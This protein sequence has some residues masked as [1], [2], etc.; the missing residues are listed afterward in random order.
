MV[1]YRNW[2]GLMKGTLGVEVKKGNSSVTRTLNPDRVYTSP[3]GKGEVSLPP[4]LHP[5]PYTLWCRVQGVGYR[6]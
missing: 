1:C 3:D 4:P 6:V 5:A 2:L